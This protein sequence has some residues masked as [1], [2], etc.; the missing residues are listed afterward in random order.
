MKAVL[1]RVLSSRVEVDGKIVGE[2]QGIFQAD[3]QV[4]LTNDVPV[5]L[6]IEKTL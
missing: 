3:M 4:T 1:Q 5:T 2:I 6:I